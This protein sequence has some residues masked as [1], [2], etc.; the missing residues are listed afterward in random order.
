MSG[1]ITH[2]TFDCY[3]T[4][5]DWEQGLLTALKPWLTRCGVETSPELLL[6]SF[7]THEARIEAG[8]WRLYREVLR[9]VMSG[10]AADLG[11]TLDE[12][13][14]GLLVESL[15][16]WPPF[17]DTV[18][19]LQTLATAYS[20]VIVSN[21]DDD[22]ITATQ[23][24]LKVRFAE[25]I[26]AEQVRSYKPARAHFHEALRRLGVPVER[27]LHVAQSLYHDHVPAQQLGF[28]TAWV[29]R[30]SRLSITGLAPEARVQPSLTVPDL[31]TLAA[32]LVS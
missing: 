15:P 4:L 14:A 16:A 8:P 5:I 21:T 6:R 20:L 31:K 1:D 2:L 29:Q 22:L 17:G 26:T 9:G 19:A 18:A 30:P 10:I 32:G 24:H 27:I 28:R 12:A 7:V 11:I 25:V 13:D 3:G 23:K